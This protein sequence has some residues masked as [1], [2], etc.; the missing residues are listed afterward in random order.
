[1]FDYGTHCF[2]ENTLAGGVPEYEENY[3]EEDVFVNPA[4]SALAWFN[5]ENDIGNVNDLNDF[6]YFVRESSCLE[7]PTDISSISTAPS[8]PDD[9]VYMSCRRDAFKA[10]EYVFVDFAHVL[11]LFRKGKSS[12]G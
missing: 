9:D 5:F 6:G 8:G 2:Y 4:S 1:M 11:I 10:E 12:I 7:E 3:Y